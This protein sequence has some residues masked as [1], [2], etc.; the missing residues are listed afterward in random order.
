MVPPAET[1]EPVWMESWSR[2]E[3]EKRARRLMDYTWGAQADGVWSAPGRVPII[4]EHTDY[5]GGLALITVTPHRTYVAARL[6]DDARIRLVSERASQ[7]VGPG[8]TWE[9]ELDTITPESAKGWPAFALGVIWAL[10]ERGY[11]GTGLDLAVTSCVPTNA[12][13]SSSAALEVAVARAVNALWRLALDSRDSQVELAE[14]CQYGEAAIALAPSGGMDQYAVVRCQKG[15]AVELDFSERPPILQDRPLYFPD[16]GLGLLVMVARSEGRDRTPGVVERMAQCRAAATALG[17]SSLGEIT[18]FEDGRRRIRQ[19]E[20]QVL[21]K[22]ARHVLTENERVR[23]VSADLADTGPAHERFVAIGQQLYR[24]HASLE[25]DFDASSPEQN[26]AVDAAYHFGALG[27][28]MVGA[29]FGGASIALIR[30]PQAQATARHIDRAFVESGR[31][32]PRFL[33]I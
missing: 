24:S 17:V 33:M 32:R 3:G 28:R 5:N 7:F 2:G 8:T 11:D 14:A 13:L 21:R 19:L 6:R 9:G 20:D 27:A 31:E 12:G 18:D 15:E 10:R 1:S 30:R 16:Y 23:L 22:R 26:L 25:V 4:G 29:G